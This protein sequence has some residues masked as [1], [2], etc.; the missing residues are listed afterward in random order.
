MRQ[1]E[2]GKEAIELYARIRFLE[3]DDE[4]AKV[5][6]EVESTILETKDKITFSDK[7]TIYTMLKSEILHITKYPK[8]AHE[9]YLLL[10][11]VCVLTPFLQS[12]EPITKEDNYKTISAYLRRLLE[13]SERNR[14]SCA[15]FGYSK[16][17]KLVEAIIRFEKKP[18]KKNTKRLID[19]LKP[20]ARENT[21]ELLDHLIENGL[22]W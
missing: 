15:E 20:I 9:L 13:L 3:G 22:A 6:K 1:K 11:N 19:E 10:K 16:S 21:I 7:N 18:K 5:V 12:Q 4:K 17:D 14:F 8:E 2:T